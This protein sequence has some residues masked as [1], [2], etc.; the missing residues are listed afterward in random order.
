MLADIRHGSAE[1][2][3]IEDIFETYVGIS[4]QGIRTHE[5]AAADL[6]S[7][8]L[9]LTDA[10]KSSHEGLEVI[11]E[12]LD[13]K[14]ILNLET[15]LATEFPPG[16]EEPAECI[17]PQIPERTTQPEATCTYEN[18]R[19]K[20]LETNEKLL[21]R[22]LLLTQCAHLHTYR[23]L[24]AEL[25]KLRD[26]PK[27]AQAAADLPFALTDD[28]QVA[29]DGT[30]MSENAKLFEAPTMRTVGQFA[31]AFLL[32]AQQLL[33]SVDLITLLQSKT[34]VNL[35]KLKKL[36]PEQQG[37][38]W[39]LMKRVLCQQN[40]IMKDHWHPDVCKNRN[41]IR[42]RLE[43]ASSRFIWIPVSFPAST[44]QE[45]TDPL[46]FTTFFGSR[47]IKLRPA[48]VY[49]WDNSHLW[50]LPTF[51]FGGQGTSHL[52]RVEQ[53]CFLPIF[54]RPQPSNQYLSN[55]ALFTWGHETLPH[56]HLS[57]ELCKVGWDEPMA[58][59]EGGLCVKSEAVLA[60]WVKERNK[61]RERWSEGRIDAS[62]RELEAMFEDVR[63]NRWGTLTDWSVLV[64]VTNVVC[65][66]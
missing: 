2:Q 17:E 4:N 6:D 54:P 13:K 1:L 45:L 18:A 33:G 49:D 51:T 61:R 48:Y 12:Y 24:S 46:S 10:G 42:A 30:A 34:P 52:S 62:P 29:P 40:G 38:V 64:E 50:V 63:L 39:T 16:Y 55:D 56:S 28:M 41:A 59:R 19:I 8:V 47:Q 21:Q 43:N 35:N 27:R 25:D 66:C 5:L 31:E 26:Q 9:S 53:D 11:Q 14:R 36:G 44:P 60:H 32:L 7:L 37:K 57:T 23:R 22:Q 65:K 3:L 20:A 15:T 58:A